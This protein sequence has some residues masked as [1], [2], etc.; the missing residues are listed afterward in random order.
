MF[1]RI[2]LFIF[3]IKLFIFYQPMK[4]ES[5][6]IHTNKIQIIKNSNENFTL[7]KDSISYTLFFEINTQV[8]DGYYMTRLF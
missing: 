2:K 1:I 5:I 7:I 6:S 3:L 4:D 8:I